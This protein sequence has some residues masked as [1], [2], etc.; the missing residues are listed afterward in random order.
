MR[1]IRLLKYD[2]AKEVSEWVAENI[3]STAQAESICARYGVDYHDQSKHSYGYF[4]LVALA[5]LFF[6]LA[7]I[8]LIGANWQD[9]PRAARM[10][11][12]IALTLATN[13]FGVYKVARQQN[14][15]AIGSFFLGGLFYG[16]SIVLIA[17]IYHIGEYF[18]D[19]I[20]WW[21]AGILPIALFMESSLLMLLSASLGFIWFF[22]DTSHDFYPLSFPLLLAAIVWHCFRIKQSNLLFMLLVI[23]IA[24]WIEYSFSWVIGDWQRFKVGAD[25]LSLGIGT[26][27]VFYALSKWFLEKEGNI[28]A[29]Y[30]TLLAVW[31]LRFTVVT[32]LVLSFEGPWKNLIAAEWHLPDMTPIL[33]VLLSSFAIWMVNAAGKPVI[34][35]SALSAFYLVAIFSL[36]GVENRNYAVVYQVVDNIALIAAGI[37]LIVRGIDHGISHYFFLGI[38][39]IL[40]TGLLRYIDLVGDYIGAAMLFSVF[41]V[42]LLSAAKYWKSRRSRQEAVR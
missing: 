1:L 42:I 34:A 11:G 22:T 14:P 12:L 2:L 19:G 40:A 5:Y 23:G 32:L 7:L 4:I 37:W 27:M 33:A 31:T 30:G 36:M 16:A 26:F 28:Y 29:D 41:A 8:T 39:V 35:I 13:G 20:F 9:M 38:G 18:P 24:V 3:I 25:N 21:A 10:S 6:G 17:Q 15:A